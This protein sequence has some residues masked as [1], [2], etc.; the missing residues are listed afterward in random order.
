MIY[1]NCHEP[2]DIIEYLRNKTEIEVKN[3]TPAD[4]VIGCIGI[5]RKTID[6]FLSSLIEKRLF[7]QLGRLKYCYENCI[8]LIEAFDL[9]F[10]NTNAIYGAILK[11]MFAMD[12]KVIFSQTKKQTSDI[13]CVIKDNFN[14]KDNV[15]N[16]N[17]KPDTNKLLKNQPKSVSLNRKRLLMLQSIPNIGVK[18]AKLLLS[19][20]KSIREIIDANEKE[21]S[22]IEGIGKKTIFGIRKMVD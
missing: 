7:E 18:R 10:F 9:S 3:F 13:L 4:Y 14:K 11:I 22:S 16:T 20:F 15:I 2:K 5:E 8:L 1:V 12:I 17:D 6:D 21:L 19:R